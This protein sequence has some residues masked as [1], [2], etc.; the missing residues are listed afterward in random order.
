MRASPR[1][2]PPPSST[3]PSAPQCIS[4]SFPKHALV[5]GGFS[6]SE[7]QSPCLFHVTIVDPAGKDEFKSEVCKGTFAFTASSAGEHRAC[8]ANSD[9][10]RVRRV[11]FS[12]AVGPTSEEYED[13]ARNQHLRPLELELRK[14]ED[15][16]ES[17]HREIVSARQREEA[18][19]E[20]NEDT[21]TKIAVMSV[22]AIAVVLIMAVLQVV[23]LRAFFVKKKFL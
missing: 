10:A 5:K 1:T 6:V 20:T 9:S 14:L 12:M 15:R 22:L 2:P 7:E 8:F 4:E 17:I 13:L 16:V 23:Q 19:R 3:P 21:N 11:N 18:H